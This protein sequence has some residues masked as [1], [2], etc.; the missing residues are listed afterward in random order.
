MKVIRLFIKENINIDNIITITNIHYI[1]NVMRRKNGDN[2]I[3]INGKDGEFLSEIIEIKKQFIKVKVLNKLR[4]FY[5]EKFLGLIFSPI[6]KIDLLLKNATELGATNFLPFKSDFCQYSY[7]QEKY[8]SNIIEAIEQCERTDFP[9]INKEDKLK[10]I[11]DK[12]N[13]ENNLIIFCEERSKNLISNV[14]QKINLSKNIYL[15][16]GCEGGFSEN[17]KNL[18]NSYQNV[19]SI[20][21]GNRILRTENAISVILGIINYITKS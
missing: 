6:Q 21:L 17:E 13:N 1:I 16:V 4:D 7:K 8:E 18:I 2:I 9:I 5:Q 12:L 10:N 3:L 11:L 14:M 20:S 19:V 15:I